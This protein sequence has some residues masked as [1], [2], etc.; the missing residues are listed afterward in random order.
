MR[1]IPTL[2]ERDEDTNRKYVKNV[3]HPGCE[4]VL[5]GEGVATRKYDGTCCMV[6][7]GQ[8]FKRHEVKAGKEAPPLFTPLEH[9]EVTGKTVGWVPVGSGKEDQWHREAF[10]PGTPDGTYE[11]VGPK[12]QGNPEGFDNHT[13]V[14]HAEAEELPDAPR[15]FDGLADWLRS[16]TV[17]GIVWHHDDGRMCKLKKRDFPRAGVVE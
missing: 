12:I 7:G 15:E 2:F 6:Q 5:A 16:H 8:L 3:V 10:V 17:E 13:L 11:L 4:W 14:S 1:K 9:D